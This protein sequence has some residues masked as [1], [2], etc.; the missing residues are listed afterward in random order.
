M[1]F[2]APPFWRAGAP[3]I[4]ASASRVRLALLKNA[5]VSVESRPSAVDERAIDAPL[6]RAGAD[7]GVIARVLASAKALAVS[8]AAPGRWVLGADQT[9]ALDGAIFDKAADAQEARAALRRL[10][11][12]THHLISAAAL[13]VDGHVVCEVQDRAALTMRGF[14][15]AF[16]AR[17]V[18]A[19]G[20]A[21]RDSVGGY[22]I[23][24][25][26]AQLFAR[27]DGDWPCVL[28][29]PLFAVLDVLRR[30]GL[31]EG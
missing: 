17:Y 3:L 15:D 28:G 2:S 16:L 27:V 19:M 8:R 11:G 20:D 31:L 23:E 14:D 5:G 13:A 22:A 29:L 21:I 26:G 18:D 24:G 25:L 12:R 7:A 6:R 9:L 1:T 4:L 10:S 30:R